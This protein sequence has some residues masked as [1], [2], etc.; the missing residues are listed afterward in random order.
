MSKTMSV[1]VLNQR[2]KPLMPT[3]P[4]FARKLL[5]A[6]KARIVDH[7]LFTIQLAY[8]T[9]ETRQEITAGMDSGF[10]T[11]GVSAVSQN[12]ELFSGEF[13][14]RTNVSSNM[15]SKRMYRKNRRQ[16]KTRYRPARFNNRTSKHRQKLAPTIKQTVYAHLRVLQKLEENLPIARIRIETNT[17]DPHKLKNPAVEGIG[18]QQG[19]QFGYENVKAYVLS[20]DQYRC[21]FA[22]K[23]SKCFKTL[24]VHHLIYRSQ[25]G[26]DRANNLLTLCEK[27]H[28]QVHKGTIKIPASQI[29]HKSLK[30]ATM[31]NIVKSQLLKQLPNAEETF[32]YIT[33]A[34]RQ[35]LGLEKSHAIDAFIVALGVTQARTRIKFFMFKRK[36]N[37][38]LQRNRKGYKPSIRNQRYTLQP[39]D[40]VKFNE[41]MYRVVGVQNYGKYVKLTDGTNR[42]V[43]AIKFITVIFHQKSLIAL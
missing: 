39:H 10:Q 25:G 20:R 35:Q 18:Y 32:G 11:I 1:F 5:Q 27:H 9:G 37:R 6:G 33:K 16:R 23:T 13:T 31:M 4:R 17:F 34:K 29:Q 22:S 36:N 15:T 7:T 24:H 8:A 19:D 42:I 2:D 28:K 41:K 43:K 38:Q 12:K 40:L 21:Y 14:L 30:A 26:S 3:T